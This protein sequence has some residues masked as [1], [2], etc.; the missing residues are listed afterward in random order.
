GAERMIGDDAHAFSQPAWSP[1]GTRIVFASGRECLRWGLYVLNIASGAQERI[2]NRC[3]F[4]GT[5]RDDRLKGTPFLDFLV[6]LGG[7]DVLRGAGGKDTL[8]GGIGRDVL[9][10]GDGADTI[11]ARDGRR[12]VVSGGPGRDAA[13]VDRGIDRVTGVERLLP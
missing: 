11:V 3:R 1:D 5:A 8:T 4:V 9:E 2:T 6:G 13:R 10:G 12:D 7:N